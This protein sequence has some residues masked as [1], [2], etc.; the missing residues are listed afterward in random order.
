MA[1]LTFTGNP[2]HRPADAHSESPQRP[3]PYLASEEL[4]TA[5]NLAIFLQRPLLLEGEA[6]CGKTRL[7]VAVAHELGLPFYR[8]DVRSTTKYQEGLYEFDTILRLHD[9][10]L[11]KGLDGQTDQS[12]RSI[13]PSNPNNYLEL[14]ALGKAFECE[15]CP[16]VVLIDEIDKADL[17]FPNDLLAV[18]DEPWSFTIRET[19][20]VK[21]AKHPPIVIITSNKEKGNL[22]A[23]FLRRCLYY[24][25]E[26]PTERL[27]DIAAAHQAVL[28][29][30]SEE[31]AEV[32]TERFLQ[33]R[34]R[35]GLFKKPG[36]SEFLDWLRA[37]N[38]FGSQPF[39]P[40]TLAD[41]NPVPYR[42][43]LFKLRADWR[44][45]ARPAVT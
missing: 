17:D 34:N 38:Q 45:A 18:L 42:E 31:L 27:Q 1:P 16:A 33:I 28:G 4:I 13:D 9:A 43:L 41:A 25:V 44:N 11:V 32:A 24:F 30:L 14:K 19:G 22:P 6:G 15:N 39:S 8:W 26:F 35:D 5:V 21:R 29:D 7:A 2:A 12:Q 37:L 10:N 20:E 3:E 23:P 40:Q 36:T